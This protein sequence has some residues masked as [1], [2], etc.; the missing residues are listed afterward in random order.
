MNKIEM[1]ICRSEKEGWTPLHVCAFWNKYESLQLLL[2]NRSDIT[3]KDKVN[4]SHIL[5]RCWFF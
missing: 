1:K 4:K 5:K 3:I 2:L